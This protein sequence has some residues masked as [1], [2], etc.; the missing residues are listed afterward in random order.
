[1]PGPG[2]GPS[3]PCPSYPSSS[4]TD[5]QWVVLE[6]LLP[7]PGNTAGRGGR[8]EKHPRRLVL[9]AIF[10]LVRG[11]IAGAGLPREF[12]PIRPFTASSDL[13]PPRGVAPGRDPL[14]CHGVRAIEDPAL[15][16]RL[17]ADGIVLDVCPTSDVLLAVVPDLD[18]HP[19]V[20]L[21][22]AGVRCTLNGDDPLLFGPGVLGEYELARSAL[23]LT[24]IQLAALARMSIEASGAPPEIAGPA[25]AAVDAWAG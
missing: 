18:R 10:Y 7:P 8:G 2:S 5:A 25:L 21:L 22:D 17:V 14:L 15:V 12:R 1:M 6:P 9:D 23:G 13:G 19:L 4:I 16:E 20:E 24:D 11:G 3:A